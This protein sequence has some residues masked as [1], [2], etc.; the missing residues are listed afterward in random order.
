MLSVYSERERGAHSEKDVVSRID[1]K[2]C[3]LWIPDHSLGA[4]AFHDKI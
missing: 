4:V 2:E 1:I 3:Y